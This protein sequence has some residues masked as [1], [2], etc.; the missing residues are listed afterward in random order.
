MVKIHNLVLAILLGILFG[1]AFEAGD[2]IVC[3][4]LFG[5]MIIMPMLF[6][7]V[8]LIAAQLH[9]P[10]AGG[11]CSFPAN[12]YTAAFEKDGKSFITAG[13]HIPPWLRKRE[14]GFKV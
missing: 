12:K 11:L 9:D 6:N 2:A 3:I 14:E 7:S 13:K 8:L 10:F 4:Q 5:R 1:Y